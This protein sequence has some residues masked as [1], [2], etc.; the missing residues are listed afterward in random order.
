LREYDIN[1]PSSLIE[2]RSFLHAGKIA[3]RIKSSELAAVTST[4]KPRRSR[5]RLNETAVSEGDT[6]FMSADEDEDEADKTLARQDENTNSPTKKA[7][8]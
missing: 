6:A 8:G 7:R 5:S 2:N 4:P 1:T 3:R